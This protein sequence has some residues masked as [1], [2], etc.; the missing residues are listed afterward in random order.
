MEYGRMPFPTTRH[1]NPNVGTSGNKG[2]RVVACPCAQIDRLLRRSKLE[3]GEIHSC[4]ERPFQR[5]DIRVFSQ[6]APEMP[7]TREA[8]GDNFGQCPIPPC[9]FA[10]TVIEKIPACFE[11][12]VSAAIQPA[13]RPYRTSL[14]ACASLG[15]PQ[16]VFCNI[17]RGSRSGHVML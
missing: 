10:N 13:T 9:D 1:S 7:Y 8:H 16:P 12:V 17:G 2:S 11:V 3:N 4:C 5:T 14:E 15:Y 6:E